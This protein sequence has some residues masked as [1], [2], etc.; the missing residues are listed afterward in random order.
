MDPL[1]VGRWQFGITTVYHFFMVPLTLGL[2][3]VVTFL[4][5]RYLMTKKDEY[6]RMTKFWGKLYLINFAMGVATGLVQEFQFGM[7]WSEYSRF[8][9]DVFGAP[10]AMEGMFAFF[11]ESTFLGLWIFGWDRLKPKVHAFCLFM[12]VL[13]SWIS[14]FFILVANSWMQHPV[15]VEM[16]DGRPR[17]TDIGAV[18]FNPTA[19]VTFPHVIFGAIQVAGGF[20]V[21]IAWYK[22]Y[23]RR[24]DGIDTV[25]DGK[26]V[27]GDA[28]IGARD[29][30]DYWVWWRSLRVGAVVGLIGFAGVGASGH[31]QAQ[32]MIHEQPMKMAA[33]EAV[34]E[35]TT[36]FSVFTYM[37]PTASS[38]EDIHPVIEIPGVLSF[39]GHDNFDTK[40]PGIETLEP[41]YEEA[42]GSHLPNDEI[43]GERAG[44][45][46]DY[47]PPIFISYWGFRAMIGFGGIAALAHLYVLWFTRK[48]GTGTVPDSKLW[49]NTFIALIMAPFFGN[50]FGWIFTE[51]GRQPFVVVPNWEGDHAVKMFTAQAVS[52]GVDGYEI[53]FSLVTLGLIY[54]ILMVVELYLLQKYVKV[55]VAA[56]MPELVES[57]HEHDEDKNTGSKRD[58][59]EFAY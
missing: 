48:K 56:A 22:L 52:S 53:L 29:K 37:P 12:A 54:G 20:L 47:V 35:D 39:L 2:G 40:V 34:C 31:L 9:G 10:L 41:K 1:A 43:L 25:K 38:C 19:W 7:A 59:L 51:M 44:Q 15:G 13:G 30:T 46:I 16:V 57:P 24:K 21:G 58:V 14:A 42:F 23:R 6:K 4:Y 28:G 27:I 8:V 32:L 33:A 17:M 26:V 55:G 45:K 11:V 18:I 5:I 36:A 50:A 49:S 3:M